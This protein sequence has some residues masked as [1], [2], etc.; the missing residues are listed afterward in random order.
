MLKDKSTFNLLWFFW[1]LRRKDHKPILF[2]AVLASASI[3]FVEILGG[4]IALEMLFGVPVKIGAIL[5]I[6]FVLIMIFTNS[7]QKIEKWIIG[8]VSINGLSLIYNLNNSDTS[9]TEEI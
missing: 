9:G 2:F 3:S 4:A 8:F 1:D 7:Y 5:V 6:V